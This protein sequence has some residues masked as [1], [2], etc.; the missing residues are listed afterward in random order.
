MSSVF[1]SS[2]LKT[3]RLPL[4][5]E[6]PSLII[7]SLSYILFVYFV[8]ERSEVQRGNPLNHFLVPIF[9]YLPEPWRGFC[10]PENQSQATSGIATTYQVV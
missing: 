3:V 10:C 1:L 2:K 5:G 7:S 8:L 9:H 6:P 4:A